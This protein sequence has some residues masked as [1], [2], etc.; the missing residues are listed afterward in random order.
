VTSETAEPAAEPTAAVASIGKAP[1]TEVTIVA[2]EQEDDELLVT[3]DETD[4]ASDVV[5]VQSSY[6]REC[7]RR[8]A[9]ARPPGWQPSGKPRKPYWEEP[10]D[11]PGSE[12]LAAIRDLP[13]ASAGEIAQYFSRHIDLTEKQTRRIRKR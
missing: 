1:R 8:A 11:V 9:A 6:V 3:S 10:R 7:V 13:E 2:E 12:L 4:S 5:E